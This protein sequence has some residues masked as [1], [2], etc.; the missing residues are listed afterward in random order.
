MS[1]HSE[2]LLSE[3][4][5]EVICSTGTLEVVARCGCE[6]TGPDPHRLDQRIDP[7]VADTND[8]ERRDKTGKLHQPHSVNG[9][10]EQPI[11]IGDQQHP[12]GIRPAL[13]HEHAKRVTYGC[14]PEV[15]HLSTAQRRHHPVSLACIRSTQ[16]PR[17]RTRASTTGVV[18]DSHVAVGRHPLGLGRGERCDV[19]EDHA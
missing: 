5:E 1:H 12:L 4:R 13:P 3:E 16:L 18:G 19:E 6:V 10:P 7:G 2:G 8:E 9:Q 15:V 14:R 11:R 17:S